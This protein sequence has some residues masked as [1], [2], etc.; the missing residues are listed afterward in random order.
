VAHC[1]EEARIAAWALAA[2]ALVAVNS[3]G[4]PCPCPDRP[5]EGHAG[6]CPAA[7]W[8]S[9]VFVQAVA[10]AKALVMRG[11]VGPAGL[12]I[13]DFSEPPP[14]SARSAPADWSRWMCLQCQLPQNGLLSRRL[15]EG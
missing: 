1:L 9:T 10:A 7:R 2:E 4:P 6:C 13:P 3:T 15:E 8:A 14:H 5:A 12:R 11:P